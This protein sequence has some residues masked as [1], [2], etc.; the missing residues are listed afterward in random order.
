MATQ[1]QPRGASGCRGGGL[2]GVHTPSPLA[3]CVLASFYPRNQRNNKSE[4]P[5]G[6]LPTGPIYRSINNKNPP[7]ISNN[8][9]SRKNSEGIFRIIRRRRKFSFEDFE[10]NKSAPQAKLFKG[11]FR[12]ISR[13]KRKFCLKINLRR[14]Q[15]W[16]DFEE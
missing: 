7:S 1:S 11:Y 5:R 14:S 8:K 12:A 6:R 2:R 16:S 10:N 4:Q 15:I 13:R 3:L 9:N